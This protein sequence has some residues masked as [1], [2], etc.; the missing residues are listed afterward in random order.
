M[1]CALNNFIASFHCV[2]SLTSTNTQP[3]LYLLLS[4]SHV[5]F[6]PSPHHSPPGSLLHPP[7]PH[8]P[9]IPTNSSLF[10]SPGHNHL[11]QLGSI[12]STQISILIFNTMTALLAFH[13]DSVHVP[14]LR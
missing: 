11:V 12:I 8:N 2:T 3:D 6:L 5:L 7:Y 14:T 4:I 9:N 10:Y 13:R 1:S